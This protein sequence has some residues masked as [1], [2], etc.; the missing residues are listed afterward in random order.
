MKFRTEIIPKKQ[1][2]TIDYSNRIVS[3]GSC[4][5]ENVGMRLADREFETV[6]NPFGILFNP[7]SIKKNVINALANKRNTHLFLKWDER[8]YHFDFPSLFS[9]ET[10][11]ALDEELANVQKR[12]IQSWSNCDRLILTFGTA[13]VYRHSESDEIVANCHKV[14]QKAFRKELLRLSDL[15]TEYQTFFKHLKEQNPNLE[16][17]LTVSP[18]RHIK[19]GI[20]EDKL[21]KSTLLLLCDFLEKAFDFVHYFPAYELLMDDLRDYRFYKEDLIHPT[22]Q[23]IEYVYQHFRT[24]YFSNATIEIVRLTE[25]L[26]QLKGHI[27]RNT[28][29]KE[30]T[31]IQLKEEQLV[32]EIRRLKIQA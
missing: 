15:T 12:F 1:G 10:K 27:S 18:V 6:I 28:S 21:S 29:E 23:A 17:I 11:E 20:H 24:C 2:L 25:Q 3:L 9:A 31:D 4:F 16:I 13:W 7:I 30:M 26:M 19:N 5:A 14:P 32:A 22:D 8:N